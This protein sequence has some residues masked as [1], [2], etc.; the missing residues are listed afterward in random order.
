MLLQKMEEL[1][2][3]VT[4]LEAENTRLQQESQVLRQKLAQ[5]VRH[6]FGGRRNESL[7][8]QQLEL[9]LQGLP[10]VIA[11]PTP[12]ARPVSTARRGTPH[13]VRRLLAEDRLETEEIVLE[14]A[15]VQAQPEGW[16]KISEERTSSWTGWPRRSSGASSS[17]RAM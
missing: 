9:L 15:E 5:Y 17:A 8:A 3:R 6:Y 13:P 14:P 2:A 16:R 1:S 4:A 11:L 12:E 7:C 10:D